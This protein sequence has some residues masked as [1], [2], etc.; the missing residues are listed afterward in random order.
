MSK[1]MLVKFLP[2]DGTFG[3][4]IIFGTAA[5]MLMIRWHVDTECIAEVYRR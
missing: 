2:C 1:A 3:Q 4:G 5:T